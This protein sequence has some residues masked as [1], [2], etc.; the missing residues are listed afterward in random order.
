MNGHTDQDRLKFIMQNPGT[1]GTVLYTVAIR[2]LGHDIHG[3]EPET[4]SMELNDELGFDVPAVNH[5]KLMAVINSVGTNAF[6]RDPMAFFAVSQLLSGSVDPF[7]MADPLLP[8]EMAWAVAEIRLN[9]DTPE[10][11][12]PDVSALVGSVLDEDG[13]VN[14]PPILGFA[15][16]PYRYLGSD[17][18]AEQRQNAIFSTEHAAVVDDYVK[19]QALLLFKQLAGLPWQNPDL[20]SEIS[21]ELLRTGSGQ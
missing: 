10:K 19:E 14:P 2:F 12:S 13:F 4:V 1:L 5:D 18:G 20:L 17:S 6:Y 7:D 3:Y 16:M 15:T 9:D 11:F 8:A 21:S